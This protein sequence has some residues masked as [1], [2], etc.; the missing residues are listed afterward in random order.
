MT[1]K[2]TELIQK[3]TGDKKKKQIQ[4]VREG[5]E[6]LSNDYKKMCEVRINSPETCIYGIHTQR[7]FAIALEESYKIF[8]K[9]LNI[10]YE[11]LNQP[12]LEW[13]SNSENKLEELK[14]E[15]ESMDETFERIKQ[16]GKYAVI[17]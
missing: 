14:E 1:N 9:G 4:E 7:A 2:L 10:P 11:Q 3:L 5:L 15:E 6:S 8:C 13:K 16:S 17:P 12:R